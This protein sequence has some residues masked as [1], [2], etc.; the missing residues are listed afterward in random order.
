MLLTWTTGTLGNKSINLFSEKYNDV[1]L[2]IGVSRSNFSDPGL[3]VLRE[4]SQIKLFAIKL[5]IWT[6]GGMKILH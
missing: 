3:R 5:K 1:D 4:S 6:H 2:S